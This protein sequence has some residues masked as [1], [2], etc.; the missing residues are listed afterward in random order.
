[1]GIDTAIPCGLIANELISNS[2]IHAF[3]GNRRGEV[4]ISLSTADPDAFELV[5]WDDGVGLPENIDPRSARSLGLH[6]VYT[7]V[8]QLRGEITMIRSERTEFRIKFDECRSKA[9]GMN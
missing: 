6:L 5:I 7:L 9:R 2:L 8:E 3:P 4:G 1:M